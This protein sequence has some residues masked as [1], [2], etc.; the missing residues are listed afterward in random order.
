MMSLRIVLHIVFPVYLWVRQP[1]Q[2]WVEIEMDS[3][4]GSWQGDP[5][6]QQDQQHRI[7]K[8]GCEVNNLQGN[9]SVLASGISCNE[10]N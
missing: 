9:C 1:P 6:D 7:G 8:R 10:A 5:S 4:G 2:V 3:L